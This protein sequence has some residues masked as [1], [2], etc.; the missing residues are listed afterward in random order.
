MLVI[1]MQRTGRHGHA[2]FRV[3]VQ[4]SRLTPTS[5]KVV[6]NLGSYDPHTKSLTLDKEKAAHYLKNGARPS[7]TVAKL[8]IREG[9]KLPSWAQFT[10]AK[11]RTVRNA[12]KRR[13]TRPPE[14]KVTEETTSPPE[15]K[16]T[17]E[18]AS[19]QP[20]PDEAA[21]P[22]A[23]TEPSTVAEPADNPK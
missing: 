9:L 1:R 10:T 17:E 8:L 11:Q 14:P 23:T 6:V 5:G 22:E 15:P 18:V 7:E 21:Q 12:D 20:E 2:S 4:D 16:A 13:S 3:I 19:P